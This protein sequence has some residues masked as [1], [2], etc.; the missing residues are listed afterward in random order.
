DTF[1]KLSTIL[2]IPIIASGGAGCADHIV[3]V[4]SEGAADAALAAS[5]FHYGEITISDLK[6]KLRE[7]GINVR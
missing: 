7:K 5:I 4:L 1:K 6:N 3:E 2:T